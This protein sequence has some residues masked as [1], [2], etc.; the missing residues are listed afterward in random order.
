LPLHLAAQA[1]TL[2]T[3]QLALPLWK[4]G[5]IA[6][7]PHL[8]SAA[9]EIR[10]L[11]EKVD[12]EAFQKAL[13]TESCLRAEAFLAGIEAYRHHP[14]RRDLPEPMMIWREG[15]TRLL[16]YGAPGAQGTPVLVIPSLIN[17]AYVLD[18]T[19][20]RSFMRYLA[21][22][23]FRPFLVDWDAPGPT[24]THFGLDD[25]VAGRLGRI[26]DVVLARAS[27][28]VVVGYCMGGLLAFALG[29]LRQDDV[30]GLALLAT[31]WDFHAP[32]PRQSQ[33]IEDLR[34]PF[35]DAIALFGGLPTD[36][37][38]TLFSAAGP[39]GITRK[40]SAF[41][42]VKANSAKARDFVALEDWLND[43]VPLVAAVAR[44]CLF[45]WY[46][47]NLPARGLWRVSSELI[48]PQSFTKPCLSLIPAHDR[49]VP[50]ES[51]LALAGAMPEGHH[52]LV[53]AGHIGMMA[54]ARSKK[55]VYAYIANW[56]I[57][58]T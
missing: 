54:G 50:P 28:P 37:L 18:L 1:S 36:L 38:Q 19:A 56:L 13:A 23:G 17:R 27:R 11:L 4:N 31:P 2:L 12:A 53:P 8:Q 5:S 16:D 20:K 26:L 34:K 47:D 51:A 49:I 52:R 45:G 48:V 32:S 10:L 35:E 40:F 57:H 22:K 55:N 44:E 7:K 58:F 6:W 41:G 33:M 25:Y 15:A 39:D 9:A 24:E 30:K 46:V 3:S 21:D 43:G 14:Y 29:V 42:R